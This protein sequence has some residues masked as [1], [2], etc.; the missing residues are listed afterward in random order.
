MNVTAEQFVITR[1][2]EAPREAVFKA[3]TD[4]EEI[5]A[6]YGPEHFDAPAERIRVDLRVGGRWEVTMVQR[7]SGE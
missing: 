2:F 4:P 1:V 5:A 3:W 7:G 6:W